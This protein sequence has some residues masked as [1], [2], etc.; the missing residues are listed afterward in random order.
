MHVIIAYDIGIERLHKVYLV[1][2]QYLNWI[3]NSAFEGDLSMGQLEELKVKVM[4]IIDKER[5]S[6]VVFLVSNPEWIDRRV[7][8][9]ERGDVKSI[10]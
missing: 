4:G 8:G 6:I 10:I 5:D 7:W 2:K 3:Q 1:M 9:R